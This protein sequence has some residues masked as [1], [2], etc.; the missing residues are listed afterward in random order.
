MVEIRV[1]GPLEVIGPDG[2]VALG[3]RKQR[4]LLTA[5]LVR[6]GDSV[7]ADWLIDALWGD[8]PPESAGKLVQ[9]YVSALRKRLPSPISIRTQAAGYLLECPPSKVDA[10]R[11]EH[12]VD[13]A[14]AGGSSSHPA[15]IALLLGRAL[16]LWHGP[17]YGEF[18]DQPFA[19]AEVARLDAL[20]LAAIETRNEIDLGLGRHLAMLPELRVVADEHPLRERLQAQLMLALYRAGRQADALERYVATRRHLRDELGIDPSEE[21]ETLQRRILRHDPDLIVT[22]GREE[23]PDALPV[24]PDPLIGRTRELAELHEL[25]LDTE[26]RLLVLAGAGGSGK[27]RLALEVGH[28]MARAFANGAVFVDLSPVHDPALVGEAL[29]RA[30]GL[31]AATGDPLDAAIAFLVPREMLLLLDNAEQLRAAGPVLVQLLARAP[32]LKIVVTS[33]VVLHVRGEHVYPVGTLPEDDAAAL[34]RRRMQQVEPRLQLTAEDDD[35]IR[36]ICRRLDGLPLAIEL[37]ASRM[38]A[39]SPSELGRRLEP[40]LPLLVGGPRDL[41]ARQQTLRA[42]IEWSHDL[43]EPMAR[44]ALARLSVFVGGFTPR[45]AEAVAGVDLDV[46]QSLVE[47]SLLRRADQVAGPGLDRRFVSLETIREFSAE[48]LDESGERESISRRHAEF[49]LGVAESAGLLW[50]SERPQQYDLVVAD[51][52][53]LRAAIDWAAGRDVELALLIATALEA[54]WATVSPFEGARLLESLISGASG[55]RADLRARALRVWGRA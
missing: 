28:E 3:A 35:A 5:L 15:R 54:F 48:R 22:T 23:V 20:R 41:P 18:G 14:R 11:F 39:L 29:A 37:A 24:A 31:T 6:R 13:E 7:S 9:V 38:Q 33:R 8:E 43:L 34:F 27:T 17:A 40:R 42:T 32:H 51:I 52:D 12:L 53:N 50:E 36:R 46:L 26:V 2:P 21:L 10:A 19:V 30:L 44:Q 4:Q 16:E 49:F 25:L 47:H 55:L 45:A 1:L